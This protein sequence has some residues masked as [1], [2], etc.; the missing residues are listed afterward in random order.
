MAICYWVPTHTFLDKKSIL[1][2]EKVFA[3]TLTQ[4]KDECRRFG[5]GSS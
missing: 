4:W 1:K 5:A 2:R 3:A